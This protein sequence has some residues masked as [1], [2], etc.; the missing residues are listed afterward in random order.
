[1]DRAEYDKIHAYMLEMMGDSAHDAMHIY[2]VLHNSLKIAESHPEAD[3]DILTAAC[4]LHDI[5][6]QSQFR[7]AS[8]CHAEE[9]GRLA[10]EFLGSLGIDEKRRAHIRDCI[11]THRFRTDRQPATI[12][13][14]I[15]F[16]CDKL[17]VTGAIGIART[18]FYKGHT[19][20][21]LYTLDEE[22]RVQNSGDA[23]MPESF[24]KEYHYKLIKIYGRFYTKEAREIGEKRKAIF[25]AYYEA[26]LDE[27]CVDYGVLLICEGGKDVR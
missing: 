21:P 19:G 23:H 20:E 13:A 8:I 15:L 7:D 27:V 11:I 17:D 9:G 18:L 25:T 6:R 4:L 24:F 2:R 1:M 5:G 14:K 10:Y 26:L 12:E 22:G 16:D 3:K